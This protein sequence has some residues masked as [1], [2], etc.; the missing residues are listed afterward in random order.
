MLQLKGL[1]TMKVRSR[2]RY[3]SSPVSCLTKSSK[4]R[5]VLVSH[6]ADGAAMTCQ[7]SAKRVD[8]LW[9]VRNANV[10]FRRAAHRMN[11]LVVCLR[12]IQL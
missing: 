4:I 12:I 3:G 6:H 5:R 2:N 11:K 10:S 1:E 9:I 8:P 7:T